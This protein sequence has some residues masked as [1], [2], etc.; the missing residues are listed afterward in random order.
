M[1][2]RHEC[3]TCGLAAYDLPDGVDP[4]TVFETTGD[5]TACQGCAR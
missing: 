4:E 5:G 1:S 3:D 2:T